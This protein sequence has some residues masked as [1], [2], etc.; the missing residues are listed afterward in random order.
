[1]FIRRVTLIF[2]DSGEI[3]KQGVGLMLWVLHTVETSCGEIVL[4]VN[5]DKTKLVIR[6]RRKLP[7]LF[8]PLFF[9]VTFALVYFC[10]GSRG[11][12]GFS[13]ALEGTCEYQVE[14]G[15][16]FSVGF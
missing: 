13:A 7:G 12:H 5:F 1:M 4:S 10:Q 8:E 9:G 6:R 3:P 2:F 11:S 14:E 15:T 16:Q